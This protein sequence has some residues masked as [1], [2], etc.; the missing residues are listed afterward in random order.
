VNDLFAGMTGPNVRVTRIRSDI[1]HAAMTTDLALQASADQSEL[2]N[3]RNV[4]Q[5][6]NPQC[7]IYDSSCGV[8]GYGSPAQASASG[9][10]GCVASTQSGG[11]PATSL[12]ALGGLV[13]L[14]VVRV[15]RRRARRDNG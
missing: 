9:N 13:G 8:V 10:G 6:V 11:E 2:S 1:A 7:P 15:V 14:V 12:A 3:I 4:T 5:Y